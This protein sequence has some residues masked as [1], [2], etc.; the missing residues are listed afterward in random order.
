MA[1]RRSPHNAAWPG[2]CFHVTI[3]ANHR[4]DSLGLELA[5]ARD[6]EE[7]FIASQDLGEGRIGFL[8]IGLHIDQEKYRRP[9]CIDASLVLFRQLAHRIE[10]ER[11]KGPFGL[12]IEPRMPYQQFAIDEKNIRFD[13][14]KSAI[15]SITQRPLVFII[16]V[17]MG[18]LERQNRDAGSPA[19]AAAIS[20][21][22][23][24]NIQISRIRDL[25]AH[26]RRR[27]NGPARTSI[28]NMYTKIRH[29]HEDLMML[30]ARDR[31]PGFRD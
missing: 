3:A 17:G 4:R 30:P 6:G 22:P 9:A 5:I 20:R 19:R 31:H 16:I 14:A 13:A 25:M 10:I 12:Q 27:S 28:V 8:R 2:E 24:R 15:E 26:P 21:P 23:N 7:V 29:V 1:D 11:L 18:V